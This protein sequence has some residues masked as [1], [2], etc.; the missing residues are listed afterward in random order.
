MIIFLLILAVIATFVSMTLIP[1][2]VVRYICTAISAIVVVGSV[3]LLVM[4]DREHFGMKKITETTTQT[5]YSVSPSKQMPMLLYKN[6][7]TDGK[8]RVYV[9]KKDADK[10]KT[11]HTELEKTTNR[12]K[13]TNDDQARLEKKTTRWVYKNDTYRLWFGIAGNDRE[14]SHRVNTFYVPKNWP[15]LSTTEAAKL[16]KLVKQNQASMKKDATKYV[17]AKVTATVK[18]TLKAALQKNPRMS[19]AEQKKLTDKTIAEATKKFSAE[20]QAQMMQK[21]IEQA[22]K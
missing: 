19:P 21:L 1:K 13:T 5:V 9:Y 15:T 10:K 18:D 14:V 22:K 6:I 7:G 17:K 8:E 16:Q 3:A 4:N 20:Y 12:V 2:P 11:S